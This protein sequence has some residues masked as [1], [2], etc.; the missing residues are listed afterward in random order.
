MDLKTLLVKIN[1]PKE[2][3]NILNK[4]DINNEQYKLLVDKDKVFI[5]PEHSTA[6][7]ATHVLSKGRLENH[8]FYIETDKPVPVTEVTSAWV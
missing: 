8:C 7:M 4:I 2:V 5:D 1:M 6:C 3:I